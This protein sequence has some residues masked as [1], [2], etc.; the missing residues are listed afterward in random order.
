MGSHDRQNGLLINL[1]DA[2]ATYHNNYI[3]SVWWALKISLK[4]I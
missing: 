1:D 4:K 2:Y 3:E